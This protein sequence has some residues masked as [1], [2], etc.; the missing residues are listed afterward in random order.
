MNWHPV[1]FIA[2]VFVAVAA[3][4]QPAREQVASARCDKEVR[5]YLETLKFIRQQAGTQIGDRVA[6]GYVGEDV[7][8]KA[9]GEQGSCA[10]AQ[11]IRE[12]T[13]RRS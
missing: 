13:A 10:A 7:L 12:K 1:V 8:R 9:Q 3:D 5:D 4:A 6:A 11:L 2:L